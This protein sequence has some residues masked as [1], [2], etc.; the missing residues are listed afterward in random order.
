MLITRE[1]DYALRLLRAL[2]DGEKHTVPEMAQSEGIPPSF[3]YQIVRKL[4][5]AGLVQ[6][7][8]GQQGGCCLKGDLRQ[9]SLRD[10]METM[11]DRDPLCPCTAPDH[12]CAWRAQ[13]GC[14]AVHTQLQS[15]QDGLTARLRA[16][17]LHQL[18]TA[19]P[20]GEEPP[21]PCPQTER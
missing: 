2:L 3:A 4:S 14:C 16:L 6:V 21:A 5:D 12:V 11:G 1:T 8:R 18:L 17:T 20:P 15:L 13:H 19:P 10:L 7:F 9:T